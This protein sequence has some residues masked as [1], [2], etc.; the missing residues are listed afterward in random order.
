MAGSKNGFALA[1]YM[2]PEPH[3]KVQMKIGTSPLEKGISALL[4]LIRLSFSNHSFYKIVN[5]NFKMC[6]TNKFGQ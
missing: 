5:V 3:K 2:N 6:P 4:F 1:M